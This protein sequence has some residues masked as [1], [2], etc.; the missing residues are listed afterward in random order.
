MPIISVIL[1]SLRPKHLLKVINELKGD[2]TTVL[3]V[4]GI[5]VP[6]YEEI[7]FASFN[8]LYKDMF[9]KM[10]KNSIFETVCKAIIW[11]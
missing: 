6:R 9:K 10:I 4:R 2:K 8:I 11:T 1:D 7:I 5:R 3:M